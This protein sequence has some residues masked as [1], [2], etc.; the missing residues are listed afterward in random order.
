MEA[1]ILPLRVK[2]HLKELETL[3]GAVDALGSKISLSK[4][5]RCEIQLILEEI[6]TN[7]VNHGFSDKKEHEIEILITFKNK[8]LTIRF[9]DDG[10]PFD[11]TEA[12]F[13][14]TGCAVEQRLVGGLGVH[15]VRHFIDTCTYRRSGDKNIMILKKKITDRAEKEPTPQDNRKR[16]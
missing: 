10:K 14:D 13:P 4:T 9:E 11:P 16:R 7:I 8:T 5:K 15:F 3:F 2:N 12:T 6:F 1:F